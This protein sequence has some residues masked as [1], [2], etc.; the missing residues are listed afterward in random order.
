MKNILVISPHPDDEAIGCGGT[1]CRHVEEG[2]VVE[3]IFLTSG[4]QGGHGRTV[5]DT[6]KSREEEAMQAAIILQ[7]SKTE[8][9]REPDGKFKATENN[10]NRLIKRIETVRPNIIYVPHQQEDHP[11]HKEAAML[12]TKAVNRIKDTIIKPIVWMYEVWTPIQK[13]ENI[14]DITLYVE[15]KR[16]AILAHKSQC[17]VMSFDEAILGLNRYRGEMFS[18][19]EG[20]FAEVF[21]QME[22]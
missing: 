14:V 21:V 7:T 6:R 20:D 3:V 19:P 18:W 13:I 4:E 9:W 17:E 10:L 12:V 15:T 22:I 5:E 2:D 16:K 11:D 8:F 1:I